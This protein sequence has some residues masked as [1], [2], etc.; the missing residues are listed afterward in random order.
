MTAAR[1]VSLLCPSQGMMKV[2][3]CPD[4]SISQLEKV[5]F[6]VP[7]AHFSVPHLDQSFPSP[8]RRF[9]SV[10]SNCI[11]FHETIQQGRKWGYSNRRPLKGLRNRCWGR[12]SWEQSNPLHR[13]YLVTCPWYIHLKTWCRHCNYSDLNVLG[14]REGGC[15]YLY[16][17]LTCI[18]KWQNS[19]QAILFLTEEKSI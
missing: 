15:K 8:T 13:I 1:Q 6:T 5:H 11:I 10:C 7:H 14:V 16:R 4:I 18:W 19:S 17:L 9:H 3:V 2:A 12:R